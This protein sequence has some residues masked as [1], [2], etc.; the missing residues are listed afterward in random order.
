M[1]AR[2]CMTEVRN[3]A[4]VN[5]DPALRSSFARDASGLEMVPES[6]ARPTTVDETIAIVRDAVLRGTSLTPAGNQTSTTGASITDTGLLLSLRGVDR[7]IAV[8]V[9]KRIARVEC[10]VLLGDLNRAIAGNG[11]FFAPDPTSE[12]EATIG[13][14]I[15][16]N[17]SG[18]RT[19]RYGATR[20]HVRGLR[21][22][23]ANG[24]V[25]RVGRG[26]HEKNT[27]GYAVAHHPVDWFVG[28]EGTLGIVI[29]ADLALMPLPPQV[30]GIW[31]PFS[32]LDDALR[33][34]VS[35]RASALLPRCLELFDDQAFAI[36]RDAAADQR[37]AADARAVIYLEDVAEVAQLDGWLALAESHRGIT[38]DIQVADT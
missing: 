3:S 13:G 6:V 17:A 31:V 32:T 7:I 36:V 1:R 34:V 8:D 14:A 37:W 11:L 27:V 5:N 9:A 22:I 4:G 2:A 23:T 26:S 33:F 16:C 24:E 12:E 38:D 21:V 19:M 20:N 25:H 10:G 28:S 35:A 29:E 30:T 18:A 15:A